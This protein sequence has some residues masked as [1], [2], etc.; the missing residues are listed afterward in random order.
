MSLRPSALAA[1]LATFALAVAACS[2]DETTAS[3]GT[4]DA[5]PAATSDAG[6]TTDPTP[7]VDAGGDAGVAPA[8]I[9][10]AHLSPDAPAVRVCVTAK[11]GMFSAND[12]PATPSLSFK[13]ISVYVPVP[14]GSYKA[15][16]VAGDA[17]NCGTALA[18]PFA[19]VPLPAVAAGDVVTAA[20]IGKLSAIGSATGLTVAVL[21]DLPATP[22]AGKVHLRFFHAA[23]TTNI[24]VFVGVANGGNLAAALFSNVAFGK[25]DA[26]L[27]GTKGFKPVDTAATKA[28]LGASAS[29]TGATVW[30]SDAIAAAGLPDRTIRTVIAIDAA[31][32]TN[33]GD[34]DVLVVD[35]EA[36]GANGLNDSAVVLPKLA[37]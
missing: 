17:T 37:N 13:Q 29:A 10:V 11:D 18:A 31:N 33:A 2:D 23:P 14:A 1:C 6:T 34:V 36:P 5:G 12:T 25:T 7:T 21:P 32:A 20:A 35:D 28:R 22:E 30:A 24:P 26:T 27:D 4:G 3:P 9:R 19:D 8:R 16:I 15:R